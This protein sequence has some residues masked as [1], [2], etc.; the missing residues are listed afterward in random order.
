V[1]EK[2]FTIT[3]RDAAELVQL[4]Q[5]TGRI[6]SPFH[7]RRYVADFRTIQSIVQQNLL[8]DIHEFEGRYDRYRPEAKPAAWREEAAPGSGVLYDL[9]PHLLDQTMCLFGLPKRISADIRL[10]RPHAKVDDYFELQLDYGF[11]KATVKA[12]MLVREPG[13]RYLIHGTQ[14]SFI[15]WGDDVQEALLKQGVLPTTPDWGLEPES[16]Y[17][18]LHTDTK[19]RVLKERVLSLQ[20]N[21]GLY[22][23]NLYNT[24]VHKTALREKPEH[25][26]NTIKLIE[27]AIESNAAKKT[28]DCEGLMEVAYPQD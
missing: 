10:Q 16:Q 18:L 7:N 5:T 26:F 17:G 28:I 13:P 23:Q 12:G 27:L 4:S 20:G 2:P 22:Y 21:F 14:G 6:I 3:S 1:L 8:G 15:K 11:M 19:G 9:G 25:G 24:I